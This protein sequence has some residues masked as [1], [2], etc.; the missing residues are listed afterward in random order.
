MSWAIVFSGGFER[1]QT[2]SKA[3]GAV[4]A[5][6]IEDAQGFA[7]AVECPCDVASVV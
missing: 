6:V 3:V 5:V 1:V 2:V 4:T 7:P